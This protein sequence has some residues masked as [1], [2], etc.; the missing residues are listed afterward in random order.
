MPDPTPAPKPAD[1]PRPGSSAQEPAAP[2]RRRALPN[3]WIASIIFHSL[4]L[5]WLIFLSPVRVIDLSKKKIP[6]VS[7][8]TAKTVHTAMV[9]HVLPSLM[10]SLKT[11]QTI[12]GELAQLEKQK[13]EEFKTYSKGS[14]QED[15]AQALESVLE[16]QTNSLAAL[17]DGSTNASLAVRTRAN[18]FYDNIGEAQNAAHDSDDNVATAQDHV[19]G[20]LSAMN[21]DRFAAVLSAQKEAVR[22]QAN[23]AA[24]LATLNAAQDRSRNSRRR[25]DFENQTD[26]YTWDL[27]SAERNLT[28][29]PPSL[30][31]LSNTV[32]QA[33]AA[34]TEIQAESDK[35]WTNHSDNAREL[36]DLVR[37]R[38]QAMREA[39]DRL[40]DAGRRLQDAT[41]NLPGLRARVAELLAETDP[42][43]SD[44]TPADN[45][46][47]ELQTSAQDLQLQAL[48]A[49][50]R[51]R[52]TVVGFPSVATNGDAGAAALA[53]LD[54]AAATG[55]ETPVQIQ[56][57][58]VADIYDAA[59]KIESSS[60]KSFQRFRTIHLAE[61]DSIPLPRAFALTEPVKVDRPNLR[62]A[63]E[64][65]VQSGNDVVA[66][67]QAIQDTSDQIRAMV[68]LD[69]SLLAQEKS[70]EQGPN[71]T[72]ESIAEQ[73]A[74][75]K[76]M[77]A[78]AQANGKFIDMT[79]NN[80]NGNPGGNPGNPNG[81]PGSPGSPN[82]S[83]G[84]SSNPGGNTLGGNNP[85]LPGVFPS[86]AGSSLFPG[87]LGSAMEQYAEKTA[88]NMN[89]FRAGNAGPL[90][91]SPGRRISVQGR[92]P[93]WV[94]VDSWYIIGPFDNTGRANIK[95]Q[96][97]PDSVIDLNATYP[98]KNGIPIHWEF[99]QAGKPNIMPPLTGYNELYTDPSAVNPEDNYRR[100]LQYI[101]YYA[102]T[103]LWFDKPRDLWVAIGSD[104][105][106]TV[107]VNDE[108]IWISGTQLKAWNADE[109][110]VK[111]HFK[112]GI[113]RI[114][115]RTENGND[116][117]E[118]S[119]V[120]CLDPSFSSQ[121]VQ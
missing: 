66:G 106:S 23:A 65:P 59:V 78:A 60:I 3:W 87:G 12:H 80:P 85:G 34:L 4:L 109:G 47:L 64:A 24:A 83:P 22:L 7:S 112:A 8:H 121:R 1:N 86:G 99:Y 51:V 114:L 96:F 9:K 57:T 72:P 74:A 41:R 36:Y 39:Q 2:S 100:N 102:Y 40:I 50:A 35:A 42:T 62:P 71:I 105:F 32:V 29:L 53:E 82:G 84:G 73:I 76:K 107:K 103:E 30:P 18:V 10:E 55:P 19:T 98:G 63:L 108:P 75:M 26:H 28:N 95:R 58:N 116:R 70:L 48:Q 119:F 44:P 43:P 89:D 67:R 52:E 20:L 13:R 31:D 88:R 49:Q 27:R 37:T 56:S 93:A 91:V 17:A 21:G 94:Y 101:I 14:T 115:C 33:R 113:N 38:Q 77:M 79:G 5:G 11:L 54:K 117:T 120:L 118:F 45:R 104:D 61:I 6:N 25:S 92:S 81:S 15:P 111:V 68:E 90:P 69:G 110:Y 97:Q 16:L 46:L